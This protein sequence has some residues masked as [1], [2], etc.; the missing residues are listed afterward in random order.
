M[1]VSAAAC[2]DTPRLAR[3]PTKACH[4][5]L[6]TAGDTHVLLLT[7]CR[8]RRVPGRYDCRRT[9]VCADRQRRRRLY[10]TAAA[11][12]TQHD[13][14][15]ALDDNNQQPP[16]FLWVILHQTA[17]PVN[18]WRTLLVQFYCPRA[19]ADG[20]QHILPGSSPRQRYLRCLRTIQRYTGNVTSA[21]W[22]V[23]LCDLIWHV[24]S[25]S[26]VATLRTAIH[27]LL[28]YLLTQGIQVYN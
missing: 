24:S 19:L 15:V 12:L 13:T 6:T 21:G 22:Q 11:R 7:D 3:T 2:D 23:T 4:G 16:P 8:R 1:T 20:N 10:V 25:H 27:L 17:P 5:R 28:T 9:E 14:R 18:N 26:G